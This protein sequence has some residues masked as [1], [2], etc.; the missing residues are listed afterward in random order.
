MKNLAPG[1]TIMI[2]AMFLSSCDDSFEPVVPVPDRL[3]VYS[4]PIAETDTQ[5]V[6]VRITGPSDEEFTGADVRIRDGVVEHLLRDTL[7]IRDSTAGIN[8]Y[9]AYGL[10]IEGGR[11]YELAVSAPDFNS[12]SARA[13][14]LFPGRAQVVNRTSVTS[15]RSASSILID[16]LTGGNTSGYVVQMFLHYDLL[17]NGTWERRTTEVPSDF[18]WVGTQLQF[19]YPRP[20][21]R[22]GGNLGPAGSER[23]VIASYPYILLVDDLY[24]QHPGGIRLQEAEFLLTQLDLNLF[25]YFSAVEGFD[26]EGTL[27]F[28]DPGYTNISDGVGVFG[29]LNHS[30]DT[31]ALADSI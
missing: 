23:I 16:V 15:P 1:L 7:V 29:T 19:I 3:V 9:V 2:A 13:T 28:V 31:I 4:M 30:S 6:R 20:V 21:P 18:R 25:A 24:R 5:F 11:T 12:V 17:V 10:Q 26:S 8:A 14:G 22:G 27:R